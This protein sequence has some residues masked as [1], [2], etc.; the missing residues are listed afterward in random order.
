M[1]YQDYV[2][3][4]GMFIGKFEEM[5]QASSE[6]PWHQDDTLHAIFSDIDIT[7]LQHMK[8]RFGFELVVDV[9]CGLGYFTNQVAN[10]VLGGREYHR[11]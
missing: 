4:D 7:I 6:I 1:R 5:Y 8:Q 10:K 2:I 9:G 3:K 11:F